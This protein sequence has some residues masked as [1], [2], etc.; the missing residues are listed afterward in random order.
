MV[1][2]TDLYRPTAAYA[3]AANK[4]LHCVLVSSLLAPAPHGFRLAAS[5]HYIVCRRSRYLF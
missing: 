1:L 4:C 5:M 2:S 3:F